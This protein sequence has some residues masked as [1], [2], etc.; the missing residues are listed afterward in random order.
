MTDLISRC[1][2]SFLLQQL[3]QPEKFEIRPIRGANKFKG[4]SSL[5]GNRKILESPIS[6]HKNNTLTKLFTQFLLLI[7]LI[8]PFAANANWDEQLAK[9]NVTSKT[10]LFAQYQAYQNNTVPKIADEQIKQ[11]PIKE[12]GEPL[13]NIRQQNNPRIQMMPNPS[14]P[15]GSP[16]ANSGLPSAPYVRK[17]LY[18]KLEKLVVELD[19]LAPE[20]GYA[21]GHVNIKVFEGLRDIDTQNK[22]FDAKV[23]EVQA[24][25]PS[26]T[27]EQVLAEAS[28]WISPTKNNVPAHS[29]G[30]AVDFRLYDVKNAK[31]IDMG[32]FGVIWGHNNATPTFSSEITDEQ[33]ANRLF[34]LIAAAN[35]NLVNYPFEYWHFSTGDRYAAYWQKPKPLQ[36][37][38][39]SIKVTN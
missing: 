39:N 27:N 38:Y 10:I 31:Y 5:V 7:T 25:N 17:S 23:K 13:V 3:F 37:V 14:K 22:L 11:I 28:K 2:P 34:L 21:S 1:Y 16:D 35:A 32:K 8:T 4:S 36:A 29:T 30:G 24:A 6:H 15:F 19:K 18:N 9:H 33:I 26:F 12:D 20:F